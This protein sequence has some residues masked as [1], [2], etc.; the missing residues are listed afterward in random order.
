MGER[1]C[2][3]GGRGRGMAMSPQRPPPMTIVLPGNIGPC[4]FPQTAPRCLRWGC[5]CVEVFS[6]VAG[7]PPCSWSGLGL[8]PRGRF[9]SGLLVHILSQCSVLGMQ[10]WAKSY[11]VCLF[12]AWI[13]ARRQ[14]FFKESHKWIEMTAVLSALRPAKE[15]AAQKVRVNPQDGSCQQREPTGNPGQSWRPR[16]GLTGTRWKAIGTPALPHCVLQTRGLNL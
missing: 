8:W 2:V 11:S 7:C 13:L 9:L 12:G 16:T 6:P 1:L 15:A 14:W 5:G 10:C 3:G 4:W